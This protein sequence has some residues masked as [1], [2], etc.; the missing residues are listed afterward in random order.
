MINQ[1]RFR[2]NNNII[3]NMLTIKLP[4]SPKKRVGELEMRGGG[5][6]V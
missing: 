1:Y 6:G 4:I 5:E 3:M 2:N